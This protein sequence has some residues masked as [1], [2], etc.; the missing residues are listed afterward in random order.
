MGIVL[1]AVLISCSVKKDFTTP[2]QTLKT[3]Q[4]SINRKNWKV[5]SLCFTEEIRAKNKKL[6]DKKEFY[7]M[8][9]GTIQTLGDLIP[10]LP[11]NAQFKIKEIDSEKALVEIF[12]PN[13]VDKDGRLKQLTLNKSPQADWKVDT[14]SWKHE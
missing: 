10:I 8:E 5:A 2:I 13:F 11:Q 7:F 12:Y 4:K 3:L 14:I 6:I 1:L 9:T